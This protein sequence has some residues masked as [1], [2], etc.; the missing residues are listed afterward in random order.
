MYMDTYEKYKDARNLAWNI[1]INYKLYSFPIDIIKLAKQLNIQVYKTNDL[2]NDIYAFN[3]TKN[4]KKII[5]YKDS[6]NLNTNR[7]TIAHEIGHILLKH[8]NNI[9]IYKEEQANIFASR[10]LSPLCIIKHYNFT[11]TTEISKFFGLSEESAEIRLNRFKT[12]VT[13]NKFLS[14][15]LEKEYYNNYCNFKNIKPLLK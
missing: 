14:N 4:K 6:G 7:F 5:C 11:K 13:R 12:I 1:L 10:L 15:E 8:N 2:P 3:A 9:K